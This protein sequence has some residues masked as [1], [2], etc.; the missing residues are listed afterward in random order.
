MGSISP[1]QQVA[2]LAV[3]PLLIDN[4]FV[5][6]AIKFDVTSPKSTQVIHQSSGASVDDANRAVAA[7]QAAFPSWSNS[8][9]AVRR[10]IL[11]RAA[12]I[13]QSRKD[14][15]IRYHTEETGSVVQWAELDMFLGVALLREV[16]GRVPTNQG[17]ITTVFQEG[18]S[19]A[20][21]KEPYGVI[22]GIAPWC[23]IIEI[24]LK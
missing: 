18:Q 14:E 12:D 9:P 15:L 3:V 13:M 2:D 8:K 6:T 24:A 10:E 7:A 17:T 5:E 21:M 20:V 22:L 19:A 16:A 23:E 4:Q 11:W 1:N